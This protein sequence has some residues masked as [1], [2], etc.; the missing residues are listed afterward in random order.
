MEFA[1]AGT[2]YRTER[3][4]AREQ[5]ALLRVMLP[6]LPA[7]R[8][9]GQ[10]VSVTDALASFASVSEND[11]M[12]GV[13]SA[14]A[15][16]ERRAEDEWYRADP[17]EVRSISD[18]MDV[19]AFVLTHNFGAYFNVKQAQFRPTRSSLHFEPVA[20]PD[21]LDWLYRPVM[22]GLCR[23]ESL[24]DGTLHIEHFAEMNAVLDVADENQ[25]RATK[26]AEA[27]AKRES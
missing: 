15:L 25:V 26:A 14:F 11:L 8:T 5:F 2:T 21:D 1:V 9:A 7:L 23:G 12:V 19:V 10:K 22:R 6:L 16:C 20:M 18:T 27:A 17:I 3:P 24:T 4:A 13:A